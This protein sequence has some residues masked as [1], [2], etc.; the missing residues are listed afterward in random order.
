VKAGIFLLLFGCLFYCYL[1]NY[2]CGLWPRTLWFIV[3]M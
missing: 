3:S 1:R 2:F